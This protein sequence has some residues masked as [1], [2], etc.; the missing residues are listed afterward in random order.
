MARYRP[1]EPDLHQGVPAG[2]KPFGSPTPLRREG[3]SFPPA[4]VR[5]LFSSRGHRRPSAAHRVVGAQPRS[6]ACLLSS[7]TCCRLAAL[8]PVC[9]RPSSLGGPRR[10]CLTPG[11]VMVLLRP[12]RRGLRRPGSG[13]APG[14]AR[15]GP[16]GPAGRDGRSPSRCRFFDLWSIAVSAASLK[17]LGPD[18]ARTVPADFGHP[19]ADRGRVA[20]C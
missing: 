11:A 17:G 18:G 14:C 15:R 8:C 13:P 6:T 19:L 12:P 10:S 16:A 9:C 20:C 2:P 4:H 3:S 5:R 1:S 7:S